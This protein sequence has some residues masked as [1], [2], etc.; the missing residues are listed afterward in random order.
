MSK[1]MEISM[2][3]VA[4]GPYCVASGDGE[5]VY[6]RIS[7]AFAENRKVAVS[8][9]NVEVLTTA[10]LNAAIGQLYGSFCEEKIGKLLK[11]TGLEQGDISLLEDVVDNAKLYYECPQ[12]FSRIL[13][14]T[15]ADEDDD[16]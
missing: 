1:A 3:E 12:K 7:K 8:F 13:R 14:E 5:K 4:E 15:L 6:A 9:H 2:F 11:I 16:V 10:F